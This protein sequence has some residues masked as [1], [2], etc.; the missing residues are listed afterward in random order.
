MKSKTVTEFVNTEWREFFDHVSQNKNAFLSYEGLLEVERKVL[1]AAKLLHLNTVDDALTRKLAADVGLYH[2]SGEASVQDTI[3]AMGSSYRRQHEVMLLKGIG[4]F[5]TSL[6]NT[7]AAAR[8]THIMATPLSMKIFKDTDFCPFFLD[9]S[10]VEQPKYLVLPMPL[11]VIRTMKNIGIGKSCIINERPHDQIFE[12]ARQVVD[13][14]FPG[15]SSGFSEKFFEE[16][17]K[18]GL[19]KTEDIRD[20]ESVAGHNEISKDVLNEIYKITPP[21]PFSHTG[22]NVTYDAE[23][24][25]VWMEAKIEEIKEGRTTKYYVTDLPYEVSDKVVM[26]KIKAKFGDKIMEK[27]LDKSGDGHPIYLEIPKSIYED[28]SCWMAIGL[29]KAM[30]EQYLMWDE[31]LKA[32]RLYNN[33]HIIVL[34]WFKKREEVVARRLYYDSA[35]ALKKLHQNHLIKKYFDDMNNNNNGNMF[36]DE[37]DVIKRYGEEDGKFLYNQPQRVY[38]PKNV[39]RLE[40]ENKKL[41]NNIKAVE[42]NIKNIKEFIFKEWRE[43]A[44][45]NKKFFEGEL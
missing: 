17:K 33:L 18:T 44:D 2:I 22:C 37:D 14:A 40:E 27:V 21:E 3:K 20:F 29:K 28:K 25:V 5:P 32:P 7:G 26:A 9:D 1:Y 31:D 6:S 13:K 15:K 34:E 24:K 30:T 41:S 12:W 36:K 10:G 43:V 19:T 23:K 16:I 38:L 45:A 8:Y 4:A 35:V 11:G 39:E 42:N